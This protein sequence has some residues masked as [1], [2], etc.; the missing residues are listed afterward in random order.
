MVL[1]RGIRVFSIV[2]L[3]LFF[4]LPVAVLTDSI[5]IDFDY[6]RVLGTSRVQIYSSRAKR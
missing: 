6:H 1:D 4:L 2:L 5:T 3:A